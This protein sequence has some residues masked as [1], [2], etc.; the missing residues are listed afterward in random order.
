MALGARD[1]ARS[2][3]WTEEIAAAWGVALPILSAGDL[4]G[5]RKAFLEA[6]ALRIEQAR[7][8]L[9]PVCWRASLGTDP[10]QRSDALREAEQRGRLSHEQ[11]QRLLPGAVDPALAAGVRKREQARALAEERRRRSQA[12][13]SEPRLAQRRWLAGA[14]ERG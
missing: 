12:E 7:E 4:I 3:V 13:R 8:R 6:Y 11:V 9:Q 5:A 10:A 14:L 1:E 2:L